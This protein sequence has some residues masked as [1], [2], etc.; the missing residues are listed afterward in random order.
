MLLVKIKTALALGLVN[1]GRVFFYKLGVRLGIN[2]VK[3][4]SAT[5]SGGNFF[6]E[7]KLSEK[8]ALPV[9]QQWNGKH[10][11][12]GWYQ[13]TSD[14]PPAWHTNIFSGGKISDPY[15]PW[16]LIP[17]FDA[18][19]GD[20]KTLWEP[21]RLDWTI[22]FSQ[23]ALA[24]QPNAI[25]KLNHWIAD[26]VKENPPYNG[27][28]WKCGQEASIRVMHLAMSALLLDQQ[29]H[30]Q[31]NLME[32]IHA[33]LQRISPTVSYAIAQNNNH[34]T[35][36]AAALYIGGSWLMLNGDQR[37]AS[38]HNK[39]KKLL[40][41]RARHLIASD[42]TFSQYSTNYHRLMLDT[43][44]MVEV[45]RQKNNLPAFDQTL[46]Q[47]LSKAANWI[48]QITQAS[49]GDAPNLGAN[50]GARLLPLTHTDYRDF[51]PA[52]QLAMT[53]FNKTSAWN[54]DGDWNLPLRWLDIPIPQTTAL[55]K[56]ALFDKGGI[57]IL[58]NEKAFVLLRYP[59]FRF[60]PSQ[61]DA[62]HLDLWTDGVNLLRDDGSYSYNTSAEILNYFGGAGSHNTIQFDNREPMP[63]LSRFLLG[64]WLKTRKVSSIANNQGSQSFTVSY[65]DSAGAVHQREIALQ[66]NRLIITDHIHGFNERAVLRWRLAP[67]NWV[68]DG[69]TFK[70]GQHQLIITSDASDTNCR[71]TSGEE[72][73]YYLQKTQLPVA[74]ITV[75]QSCQIRSEYYF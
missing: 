54:N 25:N 70:N 17:D 18:T 74:E 5:I 9:N 35:S 67:G 19:V 11:Y 71:L 32:L 53:L 56:S 68:H 12:F 33:H 14:H 10:T 6:D 64:S 46:Y 58:R 30:S 1:L 69:N 59:R 15:R 16:W 36:E 62:L 27:P 22:A 38:W 31:K 63:R 26:W 66:D 4:I 28:N 23:D 43:Y 39:G 51:R 40:E 75:L 20:I 8:I 44:S 73:R 60:R 37:G 41:N 65:R 34:G 72:S 7:L 55:Q 21:S 42:G 2:P 52:V 13:V 57:C 49:T 3:K 24:G 47:Q 50:D 48:F 29:A 45:W 61:N